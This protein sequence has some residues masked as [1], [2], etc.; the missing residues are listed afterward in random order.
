MS[1]KRD[2]KQARP[3]KG[4]ACGK[5][6][7]TAKV[8]N[9]DQ[10]IECEKCETWFHLACTN[11]SEAAYAVLVKEELFDDIIWCCDVCRP[12]VRKA[13]EIMD[14]LEDKI[15]NVDKKIEDFKSTVDQRLENIE[16]S[17]KSKDSNVSTIIESKIKDVAKNF[18]NVDNSGKESLRKI[19]NLEEK[20]EQQNEIKDKERRNKNLILYN[21]PE[22]LASDANDRVKDDCLKIK[23]IFKRNSF[24]VSPENVINIY[25]LGAKKEKKEENENQ[26]NENQDKD[27]PRPLLLKFDTAEY[28]KSV[29]NSCSG[30]YYEVKKEN[31]ICK[32]DIHYSLDLTKKERDERKELV[33]K[34]KERR[35]AGEKNLIIKNGK[36]IVNVRKNFPNEAQPSLRRSWASLFQ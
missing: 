7:C 12:K 30:L 5:S 9:T 34:M 18:T 31:E 17:L 29:L 3:Q 36:I 4:S 26:D 8:K 2:S 24:T 19:T 11:F 28:K 25:R 33:N 15:N 23:D 22:S 20:L 1:P 10:G 13:I 14:L 6:G 27:K 16:K 21:V 32:I 35:R